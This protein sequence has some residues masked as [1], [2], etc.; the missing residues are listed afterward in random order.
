MVALGGTVTLGLLLLSA[1]L[2]AEGAGTVRLTVQ[3][4]VPGALIVDGEQFN[5]L[6]WEK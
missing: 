4:A 1:M 6:S 5:P 3:T 2:V